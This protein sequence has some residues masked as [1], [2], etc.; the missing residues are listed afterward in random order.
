MYSCSAAATP[1]LIHTHA[2][3]RSTVFVQRKWQMCDRHRCSRRS[4]SLLRARFARSSLLLLRSAS[5]ASKRTVITTKPLSPLLYGRRRRRRV[6]RAAGRTTGGHCHVH[7]PSA[8]RFASVRQFAKEQVDRK[9]GLIVLMTKG[10]IKTVQSSS[11][12]MRLD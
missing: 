11:I 8:V 6:K 4:R 10:R 5:Q 9:R 2:S 12:S 3:F 1:G 7:V